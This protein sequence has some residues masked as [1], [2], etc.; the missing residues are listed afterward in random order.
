MTFLPMFM[1][2]LTPEMVRRAEEELG[3]TP[4][5][6]IQALK[7]LRRLINAEA[8]F[9]PLM[10]DAFLVR[11]LR[12]K[13]YNVQ[14]A[15]NTLRNFYT[16]KVRYSKVLTDFKPSE[17][18]TVLE[19]NNLLIVPRRLPDGT[20][21]GILR[22]GD[23]DMDKATSDDFVAACFVCTEIGIE[24]EATQVCGAVLVFD[25]NNFTLRMIKHF[26]SPTLLL[27][28]VRLV[29]VRNVSDFFLFITPNFKCCL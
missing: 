13:K 6:R 12:A 15:F 17:V 27:R 7:D 8:D 25:W 18:K 4:E 28:V 9:R 24:P 3:E 22:M 20:A 10:D 16:F 2:G 5:V 21:V 26:A 29:Q 11:F 1:E 14:K 19:M 23:F